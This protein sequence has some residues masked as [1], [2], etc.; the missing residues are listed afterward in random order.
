MKHK[1]ICKNA[2]ELFDK[3]VEYNANRFFVNDGC[4]YGRVE[5]AYGTKAIIHCYSDKK[6]TNKINKIKVDLNDTTDHILNVEIK[7]DDN[8]FTLAE[9]KAKA[10]DTIVETFSV[11]IET[12]ED[13]IH[14]L[15]MAEKDENH[16]AY[17]SVEGVASERINN[18]NYKILKELGLEEV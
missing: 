11:Q 9:L 12:T 1:I 13:G 5:E 6:L 7:D 3:L 8:E 2:K 18:R 10:F 4:W 16:V 15:H 17:T 14:Y